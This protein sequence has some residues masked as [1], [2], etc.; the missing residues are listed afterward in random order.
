MAIPEGDVRAHFGEGFADS[1]HGSAGER[2]IAGECETT[3]LRGEQAGDHAHRGA[4]VA[5]VEGV[6]GWGNASADAIDFYAA[7]VELADPRAEGLHARESRRAVSAGGEVGEARGAFS[8]CAEHG[9]AMA[10][11]L[12]AGEAQGAEDVARGADDAF[13]GGGGQR[14][15]GKWGQCQFTGSRN[16]Y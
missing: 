6:I 3:L 10:D 14:G 12:V 8:E 16:C 4:G 15:S 13:F 9:I 1:L 11:G 7:V 5:A 2:G